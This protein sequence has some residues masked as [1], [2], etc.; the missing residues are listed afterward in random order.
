LQETNAPRFAHFIGERQYLTSVTPTALERYQHSRKLRRTEAPIA[1]ELKD[2]VY[3]CG[4]G[5]KGY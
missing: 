5:L 2:P 4:Q 3:G 1:D